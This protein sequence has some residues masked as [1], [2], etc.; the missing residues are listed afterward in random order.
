MPSVRTDK[1]KRL[2]AAYAVAKQAEREIY[3]LLIESIEPGQREAWQIVRQCS[4]IDSSALAHE[5]KIKINHAS[6]ILKQLYEVGLITREGERSDEGR[7]FWYK[8][9]GHHD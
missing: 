6:T 3:S 4:E 9:V 5:M 2:A 7:V 8:A 1:L